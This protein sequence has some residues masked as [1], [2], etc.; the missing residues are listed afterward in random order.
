MFLIRWIDCEVDAINRPCE[1]D[2]SLPAL[3]CPIVFS[4]LL[5]DTMIEVDTE[6][7]DEEAAAGVAA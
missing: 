6:E 3:Q 1:S 5:Q 2:K 7:E 4:F